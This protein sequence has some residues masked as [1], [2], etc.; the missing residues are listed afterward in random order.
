[1]DRVIERLKV[2]AQGRT[3]VRAVIL[4]SSRAAA[5]GNVDAFSDYDVILCVTDVMPY[6]RDRSWLG[7]FGPLLVVYHDPLR[8]ERGHNC[9]RE[10]TQYEN[11]LKIDFNVIPVA[12][13]LSMAAAAELP[14]ELDVGY[15]VLLD[16]DGLTV[17]LKP[18]S[19]RAHIPVPPDQSAYLTLIEEF[20]HEGTYVVKHLW[21]GDLMAAKYNFDHMMKYVNLRTMLVW[22]FELDNNWSIKPGDYGRGLKK[23][24]TPEIWARLESTYVGA[25]WEEN[26]AAFFQTVALFRDVA[27]EVGVRLGYAYPI[28]MD[29]RCVRYF[30][31]VRKLDRHATD[32]IEF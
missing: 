22:R 27:I 29:R 18:P 19:Y 3:D 25:G 23:H 2:W 1:M 16:K 12:L 14:D 13:L 21:R 26:W 6:Y 9:F 30:E 32:I 4:T 28:E 24:L 31:R 8:N 10:I 11:G 17:G 7:D 15:I 5:N 20:F